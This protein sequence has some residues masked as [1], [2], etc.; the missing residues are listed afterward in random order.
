MEELSAAEDAAK[1]IDTLSVTSPDSPTI[2]KTL[3]RAYD[4]ERRP[5]VPT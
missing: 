4:Q 5:A 3:R 2:V 1:T